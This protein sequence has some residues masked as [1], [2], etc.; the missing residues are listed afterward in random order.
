MSNVAK[1][2]YVLRQNGS[3]SGYGKP[4]T[5]FRQKNLSSSLESSKVNQTVFLVDDV[6]YGVK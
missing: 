6:I 3:M 1:P 2:T 5:Y 4:K